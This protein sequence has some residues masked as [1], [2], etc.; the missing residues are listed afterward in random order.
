MPSKSKQGLS[1]MSKVRQDANKR[2]VADVLHDNVDEITFGRV[3]KHLGDRKILVMYKDKKEHIATIRGLL[4]KRGIT[5]IMVNDIVILSA[6]EFDTRA[7]SDNE[8]F[9]VVGVLDKK[10]ASQL[11]KEGRI[12]K[13]Y[14]SVDGSAGDDDAGDVFEFDYDAPVDIDKI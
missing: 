7:G 12:P 2:I 13:W 9:D 10:A 4:S 3:S 14:M 8:V 6:R 1:K 5:P 11:V